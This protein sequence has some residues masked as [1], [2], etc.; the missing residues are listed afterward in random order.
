MFTDL[1]LSQQKRILLCRAHLQWACFIVKWNADIGNLQPF[2][3]LSAQNP[4]PLHFLSSAW[5]GETAA[6][7]SASRA[8][9]GQ[10]AVRSP[11][12][13]GIK[14]E[15]ELYRKDLTERTANVIKCT[16]N[17]RPINK[18]FLGSHPSYVTHLITHMWLIVKACWRTKDLAVCVH[19]FQLV[20]SDVHGIYCS[21]Q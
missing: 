12:T 4:S 5:P 17:H 3:D 18:P 10:A 9:S 21:L 20:S 6:G 2:W 19:K 13:P 16:L 15:R 8:L 1:F 7:G 14:E 11:D